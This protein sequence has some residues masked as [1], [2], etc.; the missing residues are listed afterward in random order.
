MGADRLDTHVQG[1]RDLRIGLTLLQQRQ[2]F[3][4]TLA[5]QVCTR[6]QTAA[7]TCR[8][9]PNHLESPRGEMDSVDHVPRLGVPAEAG[10]RPK[11]KQLR[12]LDGRGIASEQDQASG[13]IAGT[14]LPN[15][16]RLPQSANVENRHVWTVS[17]QHD[18]DAPVIHVGSDDRET[19]IAL[20]QLA[21]PSG[22]EIV[23]MG[24]DYGDE[25]M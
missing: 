9:P 22:K 20:D 15:L 3:C 5:Q 2:Y 17:A 12:T 11:R 1:E 6:N 19:W 7:R 25:C 16:S 8:R 4:L 18:I 14:E 24:E 21:Q 10:A 13:R 23:E